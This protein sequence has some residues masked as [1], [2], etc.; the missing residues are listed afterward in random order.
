MM[1]QNTTAK[2]LVIDHNTVIDGWTKEKVQD[3]VCSSDKA[4]VRAIILVNSKQTADEKRSG[5]TCHWNSRGWSMTDAKRGKKW[6]YYVTDG[7]GL[8]NWEKGKIR[9]VMRKYWRQLL[10]EIARRNGFVPVSR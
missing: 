3:L 5:T 10:A 6:A 4:L 2:T 1:E 7:Y 9:L 8:R